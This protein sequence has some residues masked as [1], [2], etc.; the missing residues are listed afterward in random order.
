MSH[1]STCLIQ[2]RNEFKEKVTEFITKLVKVSISKRLSDKLRRRGIFEG[3]QQIDFLKKYMTS[4]EERIAPAILHFFKVMDPNSDVSPLKRYFDSS[5]RHKHDCFILHLASLLVWKKNLVI[6][7]LILR[8]LLICWRK[9][10]RRKRVL[11]IKDTKVRRFV[12]NT[13]IV[14]IRKGVFRN[15]CGNMTTSENLLLTE[16]LNSSINLI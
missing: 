6:T 9:Y 7:F 16:V 4:D 11:S 13:L 8:K 3:R 1:T 2:K 5:N 12:P 14:D 15:T 10:Q